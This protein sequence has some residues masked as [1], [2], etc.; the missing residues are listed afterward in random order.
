LATIPLSRNRLATLNPSAIAV[1]NPVAYVPQV[2]GY[3]TGMALGL[4]PLA[5][6]Y[7][8]RLF[9]AVAAIG[10]TFLAIRRMPFHRYALAAIALLPTIVF[11]RSTL[12]A[13][14]LTNAVAFLF[15]ANVFVAMTDT[16]RLTPAAIGTIA[17]SA[18]LIAQCKSAYLV[19]PPLAL[20]IP[21]A[22]YGSRWRWLLASAAIVL[23][24]T[25][26][27]IAWMVVLKHTYF[28]GIHYHTWAGSVYPDG[29][30][31]RILA[32][33]PAYLGVLLRTVF[34]SNF[35]PSALLG[36]IGIFGPPVEMPVTFYAILLA[37]LVF[38]VAGE[39]DEDVARVPEAARWFA[40]GAFVAGFLLILTLL[41]V[42]WDGLGADTIAGF[43]GR[44]LYPLAAP[45][46]MLLP[47]ACPR[48]YFGIDASR[49]VGVL[50]TTALVGT[51]FV[52][53]TTYWA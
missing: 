53:W 18:F 24:G 1:L 51:V 14:Q 47:R 4:P 13:D 28:A 12:D 36:F 39:G 11:S 6:F 3:W 27:S 22:R 17:V 10:L 38:V 49:W 46:L 50:G 16:K 37:A 5:L 52:T 35:V 25:A 7:L 19:L 15:A 41:Y 30:V 2:S 21:V 33:P 42:Q 23:P 31:A 43:Q 29:Q 32:N 44:Y 9:G 48:T 45:L 40:V 20:A 8:G 26:L 34:A